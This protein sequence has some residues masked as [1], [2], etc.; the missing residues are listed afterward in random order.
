MWHGEA[1]VPSVGGLVG[2][3]RD[4][5]EGGGGGQDSGPGPC[6]GPDCVWRCRE[7]GQQEWGQEGVKVRGL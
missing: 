4:C 5:P 2:G 6:A 3:R 1:C 7:R